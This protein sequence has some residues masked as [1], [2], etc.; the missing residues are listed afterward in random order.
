MQSR[1][2]EIERIY[3]DDKF[4]TALYCGDLRG[5]CR[6]LAN[7]GS[8]YITSVH[9]KHAAG[10]NDLNTM[11]FL[12]ND[13]HVLPCKRA[14]RCSFFCCLWKTFEILLERIN[15]F[16]PTSDDCKAIYEFACCLFSMNIK[17]MHYG[18]GYGYDEQIFFLH[19]H[20]LYESPS[21]DI[22]Y[23]QYGLV[24][25]SQICMSSPP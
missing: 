20:I 1:T 6:S 13:L 2:I 4:R 16:T 8:H 14:L 7:G 21:H 25:T 3:V 18:D 23:Q 22:N 17:K 5:M 11:L 9:V 12:L 10:V 15:I 24:C 19:L